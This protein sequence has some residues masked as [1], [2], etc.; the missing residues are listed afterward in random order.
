MA[1]MSLAVVNS[2]GCFTQQRAADNSDEMSREDWQAQVTASRARAETMR[3]ERRSLSPQQP[4]VE[5]IAQQ[6]SRQVLEDDSLL[7]GDIISTNRD[8]FS[9]RARRMGAESPAISCASADQQGRG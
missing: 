9:F 8:C 2:T 7:P 4:T 3:R 5:E 1:T 6:N